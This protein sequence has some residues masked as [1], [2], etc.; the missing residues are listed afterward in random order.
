MHKKLVLTGL[1]VAVCLSY[2]LSLTLFNFRGIP[3]LFRL[4]TGLYCPGCGVTRMCLALLRLDFAAAFYSNPVIFCGLPFIF[5]FVLRLYFGWLFEKPYR[6]SRVGQVIL[7]ILLAAL[8]IFGFWR[9]LL[10]LLN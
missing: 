5:Y 7:Y 10:L 8:V 9:N 1:A 3:C 6:P 2:C 4:L